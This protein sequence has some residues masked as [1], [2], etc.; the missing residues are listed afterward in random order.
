MVLVPGAAVG[1]IGV[2]VN[3]V[4]AA[5]AFNANALFMSVTVGRLVSSFA[6]FGTISVD[7]K[8]GRMSAIITFVIAPVAAGTYTA[9][10][11]R[12]PDGIVGR[13]GATADKPS[14]NTRVP[15][16]VIAT[17]THLAV[18]IGAASHGVDPPANDISTFCELKNDPARTFTDIFG[19]SC[20][21]TLRGA[22]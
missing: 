13:V 7:R 22:A 3:D 10:S 15:T 14:T 12:L 18:E 6:R 21:V 8:N 5:S 9:A 11:G 17:I 20:A 19:T 16:S 4:S 1:A 2:P